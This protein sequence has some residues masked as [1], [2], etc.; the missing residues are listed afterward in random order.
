M[1]PFV[2][3]TILVTSF[4]AGVSFTL[5]SSSVV[6]L[7]TTE[8][9]DALCIHCRH[10]TLDPDEVRSKICQVIGSLVGSLFE[11]I[12]DAAVNEIVHILVDA[13]KG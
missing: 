2:L 12:P 13:N 8:L 6:V 7:N 10:L 11:G 3:T 1:P 9:S 5:R 4:F